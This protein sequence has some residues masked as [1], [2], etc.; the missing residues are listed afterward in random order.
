MIDFY[1]KYLLQMVK[2]E[3]MTCSYESKM[4]KILLRLVE[5][6]KVDQSSITFQKRAKFFD[7]YAYRV[8]ISP[9]LENWHK[10]DEL[11]NEIIT[12]L[13]PLGAFVIA[14]NSYDIYV[15]GNDPKI[16]QVI[17]KK[18][19]NFWINAICQTNK[20]YWHMP[21][22]K[23]KFRNSLFY[24][25]YKFRIKMK[26]KKWGENE[27]NINQLNELDMNHK[28]VC[29]KFSNSKTDT[30]PEGVVRDTYIYVEK[31]NQVLVIKLMF[32]IQV[33]EVVERP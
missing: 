18:T 14:K 2:C 5:T 15:Y 11:K 8:S 9:T 22:P 29:K 3:I 24:G 19:K 7:K 16:L 28:L 12:D 6:E 13:E 32:G 4:N 26:D 25:Q 23:S 30:T 1:A 27:I 31:L 17:S 20:D 33:G 10:F 21:L